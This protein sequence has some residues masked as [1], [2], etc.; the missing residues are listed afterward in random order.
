MSI[1]YLYNK[2]KSSKKKYN[3]ILNEYIIEPAKLKS[4]SIVKPKKGTYNK[5]YEWYQFINGSPGGGYW[6]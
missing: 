5:N 4:F 1:E 2:K 6:I 3:E